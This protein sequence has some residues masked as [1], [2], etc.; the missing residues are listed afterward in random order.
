MLI[1]IIYFL[2]A[3]CLWTVWDLR[4]RE[5]LLW[6]ILLVLTVG[7]LWQ[8]LRGACWTG[9]I[10][11]GI[12]FGAAACGFSRAT[13]D[14]FGMGDGLVILC[15]GVYH[16]FA[17]ALSVSLAGLFLASAVS[18]FLMVI[19]GWDRQ[20]SIPLIPCFLAGYVWMLLLRVTL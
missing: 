4:Y 14:R 1:T 17:Q 18:L 3:A 9:D 6:Q 10:L 20:R 12:A 15:F 2:F 16:G 5:I 11:G 8:M 13:K 19:R 7:V